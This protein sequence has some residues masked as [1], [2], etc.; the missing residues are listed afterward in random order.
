MPKMP[1][2]YKSNEN[3]N[4]FDNEVAK[5]YILQTLK[6]VFSKYLPRPIPIANMLKWTYRRDLLVE[7]YAA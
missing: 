1:S 6:N 2:T 3:V 4:I 7:R 5:K